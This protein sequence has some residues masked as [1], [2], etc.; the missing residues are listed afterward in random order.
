[1]TTRNTNSYR[2]KI[3]VL[4]AGYVYRLHWTTDTVRG[5]VRYPTPHSRDTDLSGAKRF[6][7]KWGLNFAEATTGRTP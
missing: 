4:E 2:H 5:R 3:Q 6:A 7:K 1:M